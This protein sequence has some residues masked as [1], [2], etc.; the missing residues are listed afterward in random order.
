MKQF[1]DKDFL[2]STPTAQELYHDFA[3]KVPVL[4]YH[5]HINPQEIAEDRKFENIT[6]VWL[7]GDHYKWRQMRSNGVEE[8]YITGD[9]PDREKFQKWAE[10]LEKAIGNPLFHWS[11]LELQRYFGYTGVLNGDTAEEVWNLCNAKLQ[12]ASMS[13]RNLILQSNVT[14]ICTTDD[15]ADDLKWHKMLAEDESFPVQVLPAWR[16]D[17]AM[18]LE[19]PDYGQ[20]LE[21][22]A[23]AANMDIQSFEDLKA[24]LKSRMAFFN[25]MGCRASDHG[26]EYV[27]YVPASDEE[28]EAVFQKRLNE[29]TVT[30][31]EELKFKTAFMLFVAGEYAKMGWAMQLHYGCKRDNNTD[32]FEKLGPDTGYDCINNY[33]PSGQIA[34]YLNAL[35]AEGNLPKTV[36]YSLNPN[37]DEAIGTIIGCFQNSDAVGKI[38]QGSAWW[39]NDHKTGMTKQMTSLANLGLLG[40]FIGM[41]TDSRSFL[42]YPRHEYF[43]RILCEMIGNWVENGEYPKDMKMLE[44][45]VK[46]ISYNNAVRYFGFELEMK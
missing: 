7:G 18:N 45:I 15:P 5:C 1:M 41:L 6:Q 26:L 3:A 20:Y 39:F 12:E 44:R 22:L 31:E 30:R 40:N 37:D 34:D 29:E 2:L 21:T 17:K 25:E 28:V 46:G 11:H 13:A 35:N 36:I 4:D 10:T 23:E 19:K 24:A 42:S 38:Q 14:L 8:R 9:A 32:M 27:M 43:R 16:P 33:A